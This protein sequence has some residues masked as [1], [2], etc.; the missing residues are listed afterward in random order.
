MAGPAT[1]TSSRRPAPVLMSAYRAITS[2]PVAFPSAPA[3]ARNP[4]FNKYIFTCTT[5]ACRSDGSVNF[6]TSDIPQEIL[7]GAD[8]REGQKLC[9]AG[10]P[11]GE[12]SG[13][14]FVGEGYTKEGI[15]VCE[16]S[17]DL[18]TGSKSSAVDADWW[19]RVRYHTN[20]RPE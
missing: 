13:T 20:R 12:Y 1:R 7:V 14:G 15:Y 4:P 3:F 17:F 19:G 9:R 2:H 18:V 8:W 5:A 6:T 16:A 10:K 11:R